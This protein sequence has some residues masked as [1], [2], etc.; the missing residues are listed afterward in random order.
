[1]NSLTRVLK[2]LGLRVTFSLPVPEINQH[3]FSFNEQ[4]SLRAGATRLA[5]H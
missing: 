2:E 3:D 5:V 4:L 1:M